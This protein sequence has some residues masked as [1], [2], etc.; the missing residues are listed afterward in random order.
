MLVFYAG[1]HREIPSRKAK[2][3]WGSDVEA[4][5]QSPPGASVLSS[6]EYFKHGTVDERFERICQYRQAAREREVRDFRC[7]E[8]GEP[9]IEYEGTCSDCSRKEQ[10]GGPE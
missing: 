8:C 6:Y 9:I 2:V 5:F 3:D 7:E 1:V 4:V 10:V